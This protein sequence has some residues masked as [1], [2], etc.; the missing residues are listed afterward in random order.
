MMGDLVYLPI[1]GMSSAA[2]S[3]LCA[4]ETRSSILP[5]P[6]LCLDTKS[7]HGGTSLYVINGPSRGKPRMWPLT[8][9]T[10]VTYRE[11]TGPVY[12]GRMGQ[13]CSRVWV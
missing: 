10:T 6:E 5:H 12:S 4:K 7:Y 9:H 1:A 8:P 11:F 2:F 3:C 13:C